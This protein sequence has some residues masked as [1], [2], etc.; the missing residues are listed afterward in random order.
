MTSKVL[1][2]LSDNQLEALDYLRAHMSRSA[3]IRMVLENHLQGFPSA[4]LPRGAYE[5]FGYVQLVASIID[6]DDVK[7][8]TFEAKH[9]GMNIHATLRNQDIDPPVEIYLDGSSGLWTDDTIEQ[10]KLAAIVHS[11]QS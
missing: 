2:T 4:D 7:V 10:A 9:V 6:N 3:F 5:R 11:K 8:E 1:V